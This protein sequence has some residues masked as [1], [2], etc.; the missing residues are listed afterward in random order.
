MSHHLRAYWIHHQACGWLFVPTWFPCWFGLPCF[1]LYPVCAAQLRPLIH[2]RAVSNIPILITKGM[3]IFIKSYWP[4]Y[5]VIFRYQGTH[6]MSCWV[7]SRCWQ[8]R[9]SPSFLRRLVL[10]HLGLQMTPFRN[11]PQWVTPTQAQ[12]I[13]SNSKCWIIVNNCFWFCVT[14]L[15][16]YG[17]VWTMQT[18]RAAASIRSRTAVI[19]Q[20][21]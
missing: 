2:P 14:V 11:W 15:F 1:P 12:F 5:S 21:A 8:S 7:T 16:L 10:L 19:Y 20:W 3:P 9:A 17:G 13:K 6:A 4:W 18:R